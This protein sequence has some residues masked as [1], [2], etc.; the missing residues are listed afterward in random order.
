MPICSFIK[1][2]SVTLVLGVFGSFEVTT[3]VFV[4]LPCLLLVLS[5]NVILPSRPGAIALSKSATVQ[6]HPGLTLEML[7]SPLPVFLTIK[8]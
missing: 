8:L 4:S 5:F 1:Q 7:S 6:P 2:L 3:A